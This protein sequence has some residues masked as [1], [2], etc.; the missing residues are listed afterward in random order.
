MPLARP[1]KTGWACTLWS[2]CA[3]HSRA[4]PPN[5]R[6]VAAHHADD[7]PL[8]HHVIL[9]DVDRWHR[10]VRGLKTNSSVALTIELLDGRRRAIHERDDH[11]AVVGAAT[12]VDDDEVA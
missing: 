6:L 8:D 9:V 5:E 1:R 11:L 4:P 3:R 7:D 10:L 2:G 12:L